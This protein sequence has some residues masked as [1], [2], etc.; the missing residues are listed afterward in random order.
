MVSSGIH[1]QSISIA[2]YAD[3]RKAA[4]SFTFDDGLK[5]QYSILFPK[6]KELGIKGTFCLIG[7]RMNQQP[8]NPEKQ[9]FTWEQAKEMALD[10]Q[11][12]TSHGYD[13]KN[14]SKLTQDELRNEVQH[15]D[16]L[17]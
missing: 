12:M 2:K 5:E 11:E 15:N 4:I 14:V 10:G 3:N 7:S 1:A 17:I 16:T 6:M 13:H 9:T 8:K